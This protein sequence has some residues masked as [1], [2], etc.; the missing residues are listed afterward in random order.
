MKHGRSANSL[1]TSR[2]LRLQERHDTKDWENVEA[3]VLKV[4]EDGPDDVEYWKQKYAEQYTKKVQLGEKLRLWSQL[5]GQAAGMD[6]GRTPADGEAQAVLVGWAT[7][8]S[9]TKEFL[10]T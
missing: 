3:R 10:N 5:V 8:K 2:A 4:I 6:P 9:L 1:P 7:Q